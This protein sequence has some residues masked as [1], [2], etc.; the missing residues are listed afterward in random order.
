MNDE[1]ENLREFVER[2]KE[3]GKFLESLRREEIRNANLSETILALNDA[4]L[5]ALWLS[6]TKPTSGL[7][8]FHKIL[9]KSK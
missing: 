2:W 7:V 4:F 1:K 8:E 9:A 6:P 5:S 3:T